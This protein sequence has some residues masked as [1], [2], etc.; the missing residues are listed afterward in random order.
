MKERDEDTLAYD[1]E[2]R[3]EEARNATNDHWLCKQCQN[4]IHINDLKLKND[5]QGLVFCPKCGS[6]EF[7]GEL[8]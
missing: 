3:R 4:L 2:D 8:I 5:R 1:I 6:S 7:E